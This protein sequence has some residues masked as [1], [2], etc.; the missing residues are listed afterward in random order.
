MLRLGPEDPRVPARHD[1]VSNDPYNN[2]S[3]LVHDAVQVSHNAKSNNSSHSEAPHTHSRHRPGLAHAISV[4][5]ARVQ[6][7]T[8]ACNTYVLDVS[9]WC[10]D[11]IQV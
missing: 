4:T 9:T 1:E 6:G 2:T 8:L 7:D 5:A 3:A 10:G 11:M